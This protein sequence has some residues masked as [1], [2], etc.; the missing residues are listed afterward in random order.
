MGGRGL[1]GMG[2]R[3]FKHK[4]LVREMRKESHVL[5]VISWKERE[6]LSGGVGW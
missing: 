5:S 1:D 3:Q 6:K 4:D 2:K